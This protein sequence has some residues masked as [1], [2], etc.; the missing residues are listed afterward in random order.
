METNCNKCKKPFE[1]GELVKLVI[2]GE[3][4]NYKVIKSGHM[5][6]I[7]P[8]R[9]EI[10]STFHYAPPELIRHKEQLSDCFT[11]FRTHNFGLFSV[12]GAI[13][14]NGEL[15]IYNRL[16][17]F[18]TEGGINQIAWNDAKTGFKFYGSLSDHFEEH[19]RYFRDV[20]S[21]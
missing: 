13:Y 9:I 15:L 4:E 2:H 14:L 6:L 10:C 1:D 16:D 8:K 18:L 19:L 5:T 21:S 17:N 11:D 12:K 20:K 3:S 7:E